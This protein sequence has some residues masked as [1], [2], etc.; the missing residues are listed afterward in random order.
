MIL[1]PLDLVSAHPWQRAVFT[2]YA[3]S[4]S[5]FEAVVL[6]ALV[7]KGGRQAL[8]LADVN[9]VRASIGEQ[10]AQRVGKDYEV[11]PVAVSNGVFHPK[12]SVLAGSDD[13]HV[14]VGSG[15]L[16]FGGWGG[17][18]EV[19]EHLHPSF[20]ADAIADVAAF[21]ESL[22]ATDR[23]RHCA[24]DQCAA[25]ASDLRRFVQGKA[26]NAAIRLFHNLDRS[27]SEQLVEA[28]EDLGGAAGLVVAAPF[29]DGGSAIDDLCDALR[30]D[31]LFI[32]SHAGGCVEG[33]AGLNWPAHCQHKVHAVRVE[34]FH[35]EAD[36]RLHGK[37]FEIVCKRGRIVMSGSANGTGAALG[38]RRNVEACVVRIQRDRTTG[39]SHSPCDPPELVQPLETDSAEEKARGV[40]RAVLDADDVNGQ[41]LT[42]AMHGTVSF[43]QVA[44]MGLELLAQITLGDDGKFRFSAPSLEEKSW[45]GGRIVIRAVDAEG[46]QAEGFVSVAS[47]ADITRRA[48]L[49]G[50]KLFALLAGTEAPADIA[51]IMSY[52]HD[53]PSVLAG[54]MP[55]ATGGGGDAAPS[56]APRPLIPVADLSSRSP[57]APAPPSSSGSDSARNWTRFIDHVLAAFRQ[58][59][60]PLVRPGGGPGDEDDE[61]PVSSKSP[62][63]ADDP[64][65]GRSLSV[66]DRLL[67]VLLQGKSPNAMVAFDLTQYVCER[68]QPDITQTMSW[69]DR[70][71]SVFVKTGVPADRKNDISAA[72]LTLAGVSTDHY[73]ARWARACL[74]RIDAD[75]AGAVPAANGVRG[76]QSILPQSRTFE[77]MWSDIKAIKTYPEQVRSYLQSLQ[78][79]AGVSGFDDLP[80]AAVEE[81]QDLKQALESRDGKR[82]LILK[83]FSE[84]CP[85]C[86][87]YLPTGEIFKLRSVGVATTKNCCRR[88][89]IW[90]E[91]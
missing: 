20:A 55:Q 17:N 76:F 59:R 16:T 91:G 40:L 73:G 42:P 49:I 82:L 71:I 36:R 79:G 45:L 9:G 35:A 8:I 39:W 65:L 44:S 56:E 37:L 80:A 29:W 64:A 89:V 30:L 19:L 67:D 1:A 58:N 34:A 27:I 13:C 6:E 7:R 75:L 31:H 68:L 60:G 62:A 23:V 3:L 69:L 85:R 22:S 53:N 54:R 51:A 90:P 63:V 86:H 81:W 24:S 87:I 74:M 77:E 21:F 43:Y 12:I 70:L 72:I 50:R 10:G 11:E 28:A 66:F 41:V 52:F 48:G 2:T 18:C 46:R 26:R 5:F 78:N 38:R 47:F 32:H 57:D 84:A 83:Q 14:M 33:P 25:I 61:Q 4:L 15:N 88:V